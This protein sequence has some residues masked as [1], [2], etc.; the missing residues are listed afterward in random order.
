MQFHEARLNNG[1]QVIAELTK[2][3]HSV[4]VGFF[5]KTGSRDETDAV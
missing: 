4:G 5:V 2:G 1:L 3:V